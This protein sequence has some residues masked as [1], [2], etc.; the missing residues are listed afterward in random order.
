MIG[1]R[2]T[3]KKREKESDEGA[4]FGLKLSSGVNPGLFFLQWLPVTSGTVLNN[5]SCLK[6]LYIAGRQSV[7]VNFNSTVWKGFHE[8]S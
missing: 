2:M 1:W 4:N 3:L 8:L 5:K 7:S 6:K